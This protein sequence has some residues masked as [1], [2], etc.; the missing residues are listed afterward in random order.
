MPSQ[1]HT[2]LSQRNKTEQINRW[3]A[4]LLERKCYNKVVVAMAHRIARLVWTLLKGTKTEKTVDSQKLIYT[5]DN[6]MN[7]DKGNEGTLISRIN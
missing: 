2:I 7:A 6:I 3:A 5:D 1:T 4:R